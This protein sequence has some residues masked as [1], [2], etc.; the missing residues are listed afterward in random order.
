MRYRY[1]ESERVLKRVIK[2]RDRKK[3]ITKYRFE[4]I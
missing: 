3:D 1:E 2:D 4:E